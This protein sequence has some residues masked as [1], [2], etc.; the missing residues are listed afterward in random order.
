VI[1]N[2]T[3]PASTDSDGDSLDSHAE[4]NVHGTNPNNEDT[5]GDGLLNGAEIAAGSDPNDQAPSLTLLAPQAALLHFV[6]DAILFEAVSTDS[7][8]GDLSTIVQWSS[9]IDGVLG[10]GSSLNL[11][12]TNGPHQITAS[13]TDSV[14]GTTT[15]MVSVTING[16]RGDINGDGVANVTDFVLLQK[17]LLSTEIIVDA[18][19][20]HRA[21]AYPIT[22]GDG[23]LG[24]SD[25][26]LM[27]Q[28]LMY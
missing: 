19:M 26:L 7:E 1:D 23:K 6:R 27:E 9:D 15:S 20:F 16:I 21:D 24:V 25:L 8:D 13:V 18:Y 14:G 28:L 3:N 5:D 22:A 2:Q 4:V 11:P 10:A 17:H 12:L